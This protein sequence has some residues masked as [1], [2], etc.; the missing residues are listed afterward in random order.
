M[1]SVILT[2]VAGAA[3][4]ATVLLAGGAGAAA[5][6]PMRAPVKWSLAVVKGKQEKVLT[7]LRGYAL[8]YFTM[9]KAQVSACTGKCT[10][11]WPPVT[12]RAKSLTNPVNVA[13]TFTIVNDVHGHQ[14]SYDGHLLY[15]FAAD[16][17]GTAKGQGLLGKWW[18]ITPTVSEAPVKIEAVKV[19]TK[20]EDILTTTQGKPLYYFT[21]D[22]PTVS[23]CV[24]KCSTLWP[25]LTTKDDLVTAPAGVPSKF[26]V[27][28]DSHGT[29]IS[30]NGH[31]LYTFSA[32]TTPG[33]AKGNGFLKK[34]WVIP[35]KAAASK[36]RGQTSSGGGTGY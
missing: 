30:Y 28:V 26:G 16:T 15:R 19:G 6:A 20:K 1:R 9:D 34:W 23:A 36:G 24:G 11:I 21:A 12:N 33:V 25:P 2:G 18:V 7:N 31:L 27:V 29:Q 3:G 14:V 32:D 10:A 13:G 35:V 17:P 5:R 8:Y 4:L 22:K